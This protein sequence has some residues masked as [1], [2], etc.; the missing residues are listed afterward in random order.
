MATPVVSAKLERQL[1]AY[2]LVVDE[3]GR[4]LIVRADNGRWYLPG[5]RVEPGEHARAALTREIEEECGWSAV[6]DA[7]LGRQWHM[8]MDGTIALEATYWVARLVEMRGAAPEHE[9]LWVDRTAALN[10]LHRAGDRAMVGARLTRGLEP[11]A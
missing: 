8:I 3:Q 10:L 2:A 6:V 1:G 11:I 5:G 7:P 9:L 4:L